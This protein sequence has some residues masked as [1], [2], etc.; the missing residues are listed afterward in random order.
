MPPAI[1]ITPAEYRNPPAAVEI[2]PRLSGCNKD[3]HQFSVITWAWARVVGVVHILGVPAGAL[4]GTST[5][6]QPTLV[7][8]AAW[9]R[10]VKV[11]LGILIPSV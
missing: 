9:S 8:H 4:C 2:A 7:V 10:G 6:A 11:A 5:S 1:E 3:N